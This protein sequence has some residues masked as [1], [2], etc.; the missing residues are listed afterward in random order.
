MT[1][2]RRLAK[3][4]GTRPRPKPPLTLDLDPDLA[5]RIRATKAAGTFPASLS[6]VDLHAIWDAAEAQGGAA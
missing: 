3:L 6:T 1:I 5:Q 2:T 4:E